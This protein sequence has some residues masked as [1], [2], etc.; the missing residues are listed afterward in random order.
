M[1]NTIKNFLTKYG[2]YMA[3][4]L[5]SAG[6]VAAVFLMGDSQLTSNSQP[7]TY[8]DREDDLFEPEEG[9]KGFVLDP[10]LVP[11]HVEDEESIEVGSSLTQDS[12]E[13][14]SS[15]E[16]TKE[17][18]MIADQVGELTTETFSSTAHAKAEPFFNQG[19]L[20]LWPVESHEVVVPYTDQ[21]SS[22]WFSESLNQTIRTNGICIEA[23]VGDDI[24]LGAVG[25]IVQITEDSTAIK[26]A[27]LPGNVGKLI[28]VDHGNGYTSL[29]GI[30]KGDLMPNL[31][32]GDSITQ[33]AIIGTVG[34]PTGPFI[35][36]GSNVYLQIAK[37]GVPINPEAILTLSNSVAMGHT[38][39]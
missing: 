34:A 4:L 31:R 8:Y 33:G 27:A 23:V 2:F 26:N 10:R 19:D 29:Y 25:E 1:M 28:E 32:V 5:I 24:K 35:T 30:Q 21:A 39:D 7:S 9:G 37:D 13:V 16:E 15:K 36:Q 22:H 12:S 20:F 3:V 18:A 14:V 11:K 6:A 17:E 38:A